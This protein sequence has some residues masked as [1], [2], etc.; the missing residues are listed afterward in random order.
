MKTNILLT[1]LLLCGIAINAKAQQ[2]G[3]Y[4]LI[5]TGNSS[6]A[7]LID[8]NSAV[9]HTWSG[10]SS[11]TGYSCYLTKGGILYRTIKVT[12][13]SFAGGGSTGGFQK[14]DW[15]GNLLWEY[16]ASDATQQAHHDIHVMPNGNVLMIVW[17][18]KTSAQL[19]AAGN[20][21]PHTSNPDKIIEVQQTGLNTG[22]IVWEWHAFDHVCQSADATKPNYYTNV[23]SA[24]HLLN[25]NYKNGVNNKDWLHLNGLDYN[26]ALDQIIVS[27]HNLNE[28]YVID[29]STTSAQAATNTGGTSG[30]GG[31]FLYRWG[32]PV[33]YNVS[34]PVAN[35][36]VMHDAHWVP[37]NCPRAGYM[38]AFNNKG[39][40]SSIS[41]FDI[42]QPPLVGS[43]YT[44]PAA[45]MAMLPAAYNKRITCSG[46]STNMSNSQQL[47]N[48]NHLYS[49]AVPSG[50]V[51]EV[52]SNG[53]T[54]WNY[55][56]SGNLPQATRYSACEISNQAPTT[57][58]IT[59]NG[60]ILTASSNVNYQWYANGTI[61]AGATS[62]TYTPPTS[63][64]TSYQVIT[65]DS[66]LCAS[67][68]S[69][70]YTILPAGISSNM[71]KGI[72]I[73]PNPFVNSIEINGTNLPNNFSV[74]LV[75]I[76]GQ[77]LM[78]ENN[79]TKLNVSALPAGQY[80]ITIKGAT[81]EQYQQV[82][83]KN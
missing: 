49:L 32:N 83:T 11:S 62:Q 19:L 74:Y 76:H 60:G 16:K 4:T 22:N 37:T 43:A 38:V 24:P 52:D 10:L 31:D 20:T 68:I 65:K 59:H 15:K 30:K 36:D 64:N 56:A 2:W 3:D 7:T 48:G 33:A 63:N 79:K 58:T 41:A 70:P 55:T 14:L 53:T 46:G 67:K 47:P 25:I 9:V 71:L 6:S 1:A 40:S 80:F 42:I 72:S 13:G 18:V 75:N 28:F 34:S 82:I 39:V 23:S 69:D 27:S 12:N 26:V 57:A 61:I 66:F 17:E 29:H 8:T 45:G 54:L 44:M 78:T 5:A 21:T 50:R 77:V 73:I 51:Y 81:G 35:F